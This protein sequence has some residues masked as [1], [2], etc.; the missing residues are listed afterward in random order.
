MT[1]AIASNDNRFSKHFFECTRGNEEICLCGPARN[2]IELAKLLQTV[3]VDGIVFEFC[4]PWTEEVFH[5]CKMHL[6]AQKNPI[7]M[8]FTRSETDVFALSSITYSFPEESV[9]PQEHENRRFSKMLAFS[10]FIAKASSQAAKRKLERKITEVQCATVKI[11]NNLGIS[12][13]TKGYHYLID[14]VTNLYTNP[15]KTVNI[16]SGLYAEIAAENNT[17]SLRVSKSLNHAISSCADHLHMIGIGGTAEGEK[18][19]YTR[20][21]EETVVLRIYERTKALVDCKC[22]IV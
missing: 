1:I 9:L 21:M 12:P 22:E 3:D 18:R 6:S 2:G 7:I 16:K 10:A 5:Y 19:T 17:T 15:E 14:A 8:Y 11:L 4:A 20:L 13:M